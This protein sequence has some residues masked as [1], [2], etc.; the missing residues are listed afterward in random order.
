MGKSVGYLVTIG[1]RKLLVDCGSPLFQQIGGHGL[2]N[3]SGLIITHCHDDHKR[4]FTD[5]ALFNRY[6]PDIYNR[7]PLITSEAVG[8]GLCVSSGPALAT[9]LDTDSK[10]VVDVS[11]DDYIDFRLLGPRAK[12]RIVS[13]CNGGVSSLAVVD[14]EGAVLGPERAK[15]VI[16]PRNGR[17]RLLFRDPDYGEWV[18]PENFYPFSSPTFY[19]SDPHIYRD[20][21]GFTVEAINAPVWHGLPNIGLRFRTAD[22]TLIFSS[23]TNHDTE[24]W[25]ALH[26]EKHQQKLSGSPRE[27]TEAEVIHG[28]INDYIERIWSA[29]RYREAVRSFDDAIVIHDIAVRKSVV[30]TDYRRLRHTV[31]KKENVILTHSPDKI[32]SAWA[33]SKAEKTFLIRGKQFFEQVEGRLWPMDADVYHKEEGKY[34]VGYRN[35]AGKDTVYEND[36]ILNLG[37]PSPWEKGTPLY[38]VDLYEDIGG[39]YFP[40]IADDSSRYLERPDGRVELVTYTA[41][42]SEGV[43]AGDRREEVCGKG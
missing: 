43:V 11:Y 22:E 9:S 24:L 34:F 28:D 30:H 10:R 32:T 5:L 20:P 37:G 4:W 23:D 39:K 27:F 3:I 6:A 7:V 13:R 29:E 21:A 33:L 25:Q 35:P 40:K 42:G 38:N 19:E 31:L 16:S 14:N 17:P 36:G 12:Y 1:G 15:I 18:E 8:E 26:S 2:V 41:G